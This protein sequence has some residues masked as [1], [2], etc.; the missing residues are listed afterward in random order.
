MLFSL[1]WIILSCYFRFRSLELEKTR[2]LFLNIENA[3]VKKV[4]DF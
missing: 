3:F 4:I 2:G 1:N